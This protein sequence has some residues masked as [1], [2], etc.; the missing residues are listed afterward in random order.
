MPGPKLSEE[1]AKETVEAVNVAL[2]DGFQRLGSPSV[3]QHAAR[4]LSIAVPTLRHRL[5]VCRER[6]DIAPD[7]SLENA[8]GIDVGS[9]AA[10]IA[11][12]ESENKALTTRLA[13]LMRDQITRD[14]VRQHIFKLRENGATPPR[15]ISTKKSRVGVTGMPI[16]FAS[17][18]QLGEVIQASEING[19]NAFNLEIAE[20]RIEIMMQKTVRL[21]FDEVARP[22]YPGIIFLLGG[23]M[24]SGDSLHDDLTRTNEERVLPI[25]LRLVDLLIGCVDFLLGHFEHVHI[26]CVAGNHGRLDRKTPSKERSAT[27]FDWLAGT[28]IERHYESVVASGKL[29]KGRATFQVETSP[30]AYF[31]VYGRTYCLTHGD[32]FRGGDGM[33]GPIGPVMRGRWKKSGRDIALGQPFDTLLCG[34]FHWLWMLDHLIINGSLPGYSEFAYQNNMQPTQPAQALW[35]QHPDEGITHQLPI[36]LAPPRHRKSGDY[37]AYRRK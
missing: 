30:D 26:V 5:E 28:M 16:L 11:R 9:S 34:H 1:K 3:M 25:L 23:D 8:A 31:E 35:I 6:F 29:E 13:A 33:I 15:W 18:W 17:D 36:Y 4:M 14:H 32:Q 12:L 21:L 2:R 20:Q 27:N 19:F 37:L 24:V 7:W 22:K 10:Q